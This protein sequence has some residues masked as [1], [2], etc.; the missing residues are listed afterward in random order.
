[1]SKK[2]L[3][4]FLI[5]CLSV[6]S[7]FATNCSR[8]TALEP[9]LNAEVKSLALMV[10]PNKNRIDVL[11]ML[12]NRVTSTLKTD[13]RPSNIAVSNDR[14]MILVTNKNSGTISVYLRRDNDDFVKLNSVGQGLLPV[15]VVFNP[16]PQISEAYVA[17][18][19][20]SKVLVLDTRD[21][22]SSPKI[23]RSIP[24]PD[25][26]P[27]NIVV[28]NDGTRIFVTDSQ[29][30]RVITL[31]KSGVN[32]TLNFSQPFD[33]NRAN[34]DLE[35]MIVVPSGPNIQPG[36]QDPNERLFIA[37]GARSEVYVFNTRTNSVSQVIPL[38][39]NQVVGQNQVAPKNLT[40]YKDR[41]TG[42]QKV[43][44]TGY[45]A[46][47]VSVIDPV[48]N[49]LLRNIPLAQNAA[50]RESY[51]PVGIGVGTLASGQDVIYVTNTS[52]LNISLIDP[53]TDTLLRSFGTTASGG[54]QDPL[55]EMITI[56]PVK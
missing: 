25:S 26:R 29:N 53:R 42:N 18:E 56:G 52:G 50:G 2:L 17:Y 54:A 8:P 6:T 11:D 39:D 35:G 27:K 38:Q 48:G 20:D 46:S 28:S 36:Q 45:S 22:N 43:Y 10:V 7:L 1:M 37:N 14:R 12:T 44:V 3:K 15:G 40:L 19:G 32:F 21:R 5:A 16:N 9:S 33:Q 49:R 41:V 24:L 13:E 30:D 47:V 34:V 51:N 55:G 31:Q 4:S 23:I